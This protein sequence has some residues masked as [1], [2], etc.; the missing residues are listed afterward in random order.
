MKAIQIISQDLFDKVRSR[1]SNLEMGDETGAVTIDPT[2]ARFFDFDFIMEG[3][4]LGRVSISLNDLGSLKV[5]YSQG[6]T[7]NQDDPVKKHW[8]SFL[9]EMRFFAMR[10]LL[11]FDTR[12]LAKTNLDKNDFQHLA[13][14]QAPKEEEM[15]NMNESR[16]NNKSTKKTSRAVKGATEVIV[17]H[18]KPVDEEFAGARSQRKN[19]KA[20][21]IQNQDGERFKYPFI[22]PAG[23]FAMAQHVDHGGIPHD[24]A[25][26]AIIKMSEEIAQLAEFKNK[27]H[28]ATLHDDATGITERAIGRLNELKATVEAL[29]KRHHYEAWASNFNENEVNDGLEMDE[30]AMEQYKQ[31]FTQ[32]SFQEELAGY[33]PLLHRIMSETNKV[34]LED[35]VS[36]SEDDDSEDWYDSNGRPNP[37]G[38]HDAAGHYH[39]DRNTD[40]SRD[41]FTAFEEWADATEQG[42]LTDDQIETLKQALGELPQGANGPELELGPDGQTAWQFFNQ[43]GIEDT[44]LES[45]LQDMA[46]VDPETDALEVFKLWADDS[47]PELSV[48]LGMSGASE[49]PQE[50]Q[51]A[52]VS[53]DEVDMD[54]FEFPDGGRYGYTIGSGGA[55]YGSH[56]QFSSS[57]L[58]VIDKQTGKTV[59]HSDFTY[60]D[61]EPSQEDLDYWFNEPET[62]D[63]QQENREAG[64]DPTNTKGEHGAG[65]SD[66]SQ[67]VDKNPY[68]PGSPAHGAYGKGQQDYKRSFGENEEMK[69]PKGAMSKGSVVQEVAKIVKS[70]Y[71]RDNPDVGPFRGGEGI[72]LDVKKQ[73]AEKFGDEAGEQA[74]QMAEQ[75]IDKLTKEW[76]QK[77][78][79]VANGHGDDGLARLKELVGHIKQK[80]EDHSNPEKGV[81]TTHGMM[82]AEESGPNKSDVPAYLRKQSGKDDWRVTHKD[83]EKDAEKNISSKQGLAALKKRTGIEEGLTD[84]LRLSGLAK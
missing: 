19:I 78:G 40:E 5:Y 30:V 2:E 11:R 4:N 17:R 69:A 26:K 82:P 33:F 81:A 46:N 76:E 29:G 67:G 44:D 61:E 62:A 53:E 72:A 9:K 24:P 38:A 43:L 65:Y 64:T 47:Y 42:K 39:P 21:F 10:R 45:K 23:A 60:F 28:R 77:H 8:Y 22:H 12:D 80:V 71:N 49:Q 74:A 6:I 54:Q 37:H 31:A 58:T 1:F 20:I 36:E 48:A 84:I 35:Y 7:E 3:N 14:T 27:I 16:W 73:I 50:P 56:G 34:N 15:N 70:F 25:G 13:T 68:N 55:A 41:A 32:T 75:F 83:M 52:P 51:Q 18:A 79:H 66:A 63:G 57:G 59:H